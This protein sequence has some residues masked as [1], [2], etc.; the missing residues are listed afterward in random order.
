MSSKLTADHLD[1]PIDTVRFHFR[2]IYKKHPINSQT[3]LMAK[4]LRA[5][6]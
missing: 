4:V 6:G 5:E 3:E 1:L 2:N